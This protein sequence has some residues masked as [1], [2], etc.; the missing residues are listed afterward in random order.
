[1]FTLK[2][3]YEIKILKSFFQF[4]I[5]IYIQ[6]IIFPNHFIQFLNFISNFA[7][8]FELSFYPLKVFLCISLTFHLLFYPFI[9]HVLFIIS[10]ILYLIVH[11]CLF[12]GQVYV[13]IAIVTTAFNIW[14]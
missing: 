1:M 14:R 11:L 12:D 9:Y 2:Y 7:S 10:L 3:I 8:H 5:Y 6:Y 4:I 13:C